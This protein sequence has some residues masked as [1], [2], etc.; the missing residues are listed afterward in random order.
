MALVH[1]APERRTGAAPRTAEGA[2]A[3]GVATP[4]ACVRNLVSVGMPLAAAV[5]ACGGAQR[6]LLGLPTVDLLPGQPAEVLVLTDDLLPV[7]TVIGTEVFEP[8]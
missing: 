5:D 8:V 7:R 2:L 1:D 6:R 3:G 4:D